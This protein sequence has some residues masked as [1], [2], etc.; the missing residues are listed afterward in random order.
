MSDFTPYMQVVLFKIAK[1]SSVITESISK[2]IS[3]KTCFWILNCRGVVE[4]IRWVVHLVDCRSFESNN[5]I[6][7]NWRERGENRKGDKD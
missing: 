6:D 1:F 4:E 3:Y 5:Q 2:Q 7:R